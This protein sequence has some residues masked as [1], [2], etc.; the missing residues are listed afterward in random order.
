VWPPPA[1][2]CDHGT[3]DLALNRRGS[4]PLR[5]QIVAQVEMRILAGDLR[6]GEKL[7]SVR[8]L[9]ARLRVHPRTVH[10]AYRQLQTNE[11]LTLQ[12][13]SGAYVRRGQSGQRR[14]REGLEE[15]I[16]ALLSE[17]LGSG[18]SLHQI[19]CAARRWLDA[20]PPQR[21][22]VVDTCPRTAEIL[23]VELRGQGLPCEAQGLADALARPCSLAGVLVVCLPFHVSKLQ[24]LIPQCQ[25]ATVGLEIAGEHGQA[26]LDLPTL[27]RVLMVSHSPRVPPYASTIVR[28]LRG[29][30]VELFC[31]LADE[32]GQWAPLATSA[33]LV[34][35]DVVAAAEVRRRRPDARVLSLLGPRSYASVRAGLTFPPPPSLR[36]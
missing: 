7:P 12:P 16:G 23:A 32:T 14:T 8:E 31:H 34:L 33:H 6:H 15:M 2:I 19:R 26:I 9:A 24:A 20:D 11:N 10:A 28:S 30:D 5:D 27:A 13:G 4:I 1:I 25:T 22:V 29:D 3:V 36:T 21:A 35:T 18:L 17:A